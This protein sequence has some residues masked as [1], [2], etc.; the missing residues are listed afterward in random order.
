M[1]NP[2]SKKVSLSANGSANRRPAHSFALF[3]SWSAGLKESL[4]LPLFEAQN[5]SDLEMLK[6][7]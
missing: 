6:A 7:S 1:P 5:D 2:R 3:G 4:L